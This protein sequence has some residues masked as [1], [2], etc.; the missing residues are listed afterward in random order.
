MS[1]L[2]LTNISK[3]YRK[4]PAVST[5]E[6]DL[7]AGVVGLLGPNGAGKTSLLQMITGFLRPDTGSISIAGHDI[8]TDR[9][10]LAARRQLGYV[11]QHPQFFVQWTVKAFLLHLAQL[12]DLGNKAECLARTEECLSLV[13]LTEKRDAKIRT[14]S[15]GMLQRLAI[16]QALLN[17]PTVLILD[18]PTAGLD[19]EERLRFRHLITQIAAERLILFS[20]HIVEDI[21][22][23]C[24]DV[25]ILQQTIRYHG[26]IQALIAKT[27]AAGVV[28]DCQHTAPLAIDHRRIISSM[29]QAEATVSRIIGPP[30]VNIRATPATSI[31]L[32]EAFVSVLNPEPALQERSYGGN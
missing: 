1:L 12:R 32:N 16:A 6:L 30:P 26:S 19:P 17:D 18:E 21:E 14:L 15:G 20:T 4:T 5:I 28:W 8:A 7:A 24:N 9:G 29:P 10:L 25:I 27:L 2:R 11:P 23:T 3:A 22:Q 31:G 13:G